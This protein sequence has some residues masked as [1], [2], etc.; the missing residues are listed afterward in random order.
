MSC[1]GPVAPGT[2]I[3]T[4]VTSSTGAITATC[5]G[6]DCDPDVKPLGGDQY[7]VRVPADKV[8]CPGPVIISHTV[9][10]V[11]IQIECWDVKPCPP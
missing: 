3:I 8:K 7:R 4:T 5:N 9:G 11:P 2:Q 6:T 10:G 1:L